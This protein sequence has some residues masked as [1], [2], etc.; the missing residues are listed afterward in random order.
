[1]E[2]REQR[3]RERAHRLWEEEGRPDGRADDHWFQAKE[4]VAIEEGRPEML[5]PIGEAGEPAEPIE[6]LVN[7]GE[8]PTLTDQGEM[9]I[10]RHPEAASDTPSPAPKPRARRKTGTPAS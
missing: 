6:A 3:I 10:P 5:K 9:Q 7:A 1:M 8:F 2:E 4:I